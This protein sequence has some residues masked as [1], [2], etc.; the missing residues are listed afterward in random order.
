[1]ADMVNFC[2]SLIKKSSPDL[3]FLNTGP[4]VNWQTSITDLNSGVHNSYTPEMRW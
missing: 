4:T 1:M 2:I 3:F